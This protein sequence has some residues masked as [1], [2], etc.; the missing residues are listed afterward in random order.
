MQNNISNSKR[1]TGFYIAVG[2]LVACVALVGVLYTNALNKRTQEKNADLA[3]NQQKTLS[4]ENATPEPGTSELDAKTAQGDGGKAKSSESLAKADTDTAAENKKQGEDS[5]DTA[6]EDKSTENETNPQDTAQQEEP[7]K[8]AMANSN[9]A[10]SFKEENGLLWP[11]DGDVIMKYSMNNSI[12]FATLAQYKCNPAIVISCEENTPVRAAADCMVTSIEEGGETGLTVCTSVGDSYTVKYGQ[13]KDVSVTV[14][15][16]L[17]EGDTLG[18]IA[19]P[20]K[21]YSVEG[22][23]LYFQVLENN[24][25]IDP[26]LLLR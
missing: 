18:K 12:Y 13:L 6:S 9:A 21:Y 5:S 20:S 15:D 7:A 2:S 19:K 26:L 4:L 11:V 8:P 16:R 17:Q 14:G 22:A 3:R 23:N 24:N 25:S 10:S 1:K